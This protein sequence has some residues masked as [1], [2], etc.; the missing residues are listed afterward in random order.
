MVF[1]AVEKYW[2]RIA[3]S[4]KAN[5]KRSVVFG[6]PLTGAK[7]IGRFSCRRLGS[8]LKLITL[9]T[10]EGNK[11]GLQKEL[12]KTEVDFPWTKFAAGKNVTD[13]ECPGYQIT[14]KNQYT[15]TTLII[16]NISAQEWGLKG[17]NWLKRQLAVL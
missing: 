12:Q 5:K 10:S 13:I 17:Y 11:V 15:G 2:M 8:Y 3:T 16:S 7:G 4:N 9:G 1:Q 14:V 6:R